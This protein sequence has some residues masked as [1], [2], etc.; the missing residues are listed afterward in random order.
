LAQRSMEA[1]QSAD[2][3]AAPSWNFRPSRSVNV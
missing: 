2:F 1:M 3:T